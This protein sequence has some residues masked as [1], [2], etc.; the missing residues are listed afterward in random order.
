MQRWE[1]TWRYPQ[2]D[3]DP[4]HVLV[5]GRDVTF[6]ELLDAAARDDECGPDWYEDHDDEDSRLVR[7]AL[8][9]WAPLLGIGRDVPLETTDSR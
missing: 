9:L 1:T 6:E 5:L 3:R 4:H 2:D 8:R 7:Y